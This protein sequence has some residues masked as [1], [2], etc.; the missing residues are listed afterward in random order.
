MSTLNVESV[1]S[2][3][4]STTL[5]H[6][7]AQSMGC[8]HAPYS[9]AKYW[10]R[11]RPWQ[12]SVSL[13][14]G[15]QHGAKPKK[16]NQKLLFGYFPHLRALFDNP[17]WTVISHPEWENE[18]DELADT[19]RIGG[20]PL[21]GYGGKLSRLL[22]DRADWPCLAVHLV[23][24]QTHAPRFSIHRLW[25]E[26]NIAALVFLGS[27]QQPIFNIRVDFQAM[28]TAQMFGD[29]FTP[30]SNREFS[31]V[32]W[33]ADEDLFKI[34]QQRR[35]LLQD[36]QHLALLIWNFRR[37]IQHELDV[38]PQ[39]LM[40][41]TGCGLPRPLR[42]KWCSKRAQWLDHPVYLNGVCCEFPDHHAP[43]AISCG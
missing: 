17:L 26:K 4:R 18:W 6:A 10:H 13:W 14:K 12:D 19:I 24:L 5:F 15:M 9:M 43:A 27:M 1:G 38:G 35:W 31:P 41:K 30:V 37:E 11:L 7:T 21:D 22:F 29:E 32:T 3:F 36:D 33:A 2:L 40:G 16:N 8:L 42:K 28:L 39:K 20:K 23:L 34:L 25:L